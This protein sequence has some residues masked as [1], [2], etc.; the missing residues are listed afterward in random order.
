MTVKVGSQAQW[1]QILSANS[2]VVTDCSSKPPVLP[3]DP[4]DKP[5]LQSTPT[6]ADPVR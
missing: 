2:I 1:R 5:I 3:S 4:A 6:G